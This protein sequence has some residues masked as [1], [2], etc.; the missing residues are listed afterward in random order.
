MTVPAGSGDD[1]VAGQHEGVGG[2]D[3]REGDEL[4]AE[5]PDGGLDPRAAGAY[6]R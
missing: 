1:R 4:G 2:G 3:D 5:R 6:A